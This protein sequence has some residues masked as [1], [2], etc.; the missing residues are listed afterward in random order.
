MNFT[1][2][3]LSLIAIYNSGERE[4]TIQALIEM[5]KY[6]ETDE[7]NLRELTDSAVKKLQSI[8]DDQFEA[9]DLIPDFS[10]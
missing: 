5:S 1:H 10:E 9:L 3:E 7:A 6:L 4:S 2:D 8:N